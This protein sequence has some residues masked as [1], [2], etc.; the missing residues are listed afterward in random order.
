M[1]QIIGEM[2]TVQSAARYTVAALIGQSLFEFALPLIKLKGTDFWQWVKSTDWAGY[3]MY[4]L[5][6]GCW[7]S[8]KHNAPNA[9]H[10]DACQNNFFIF[11][12]NFYKHIISGVEA[13][14][15]QLKAKNNGK[16][17]PAFSNE[18]RLL[19]LPSHPVCIMV[20]LVSVRPFSPWCKF[21]QNIAIYWCCWL[22]NGFL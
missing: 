4:L 12:L 2:W 5:P 14:F 10:W 9:L 13:N 20:R 22:L 17:C 16:P 18:K 15:L 21:F 6:L 19:K 11:S 7:V 8:K 1:L 3:S